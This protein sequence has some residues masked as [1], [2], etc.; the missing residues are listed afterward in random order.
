MLQA[1]LSTALCMCSQIFAP[2]AAYTVLLKTIILVVFIGLAHGLFILPV[3]L[4]FLA[5]KKQKKPK[6]EEIATEQSCLSNAI[7]G[8]HC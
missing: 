6:L 1:G 8:E 2:L 7:N 4:S 5:V 3:V